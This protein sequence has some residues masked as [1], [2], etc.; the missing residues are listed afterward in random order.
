MV[1]IEE[2]ALG[3]SKDDKAPEKIIG[4]E[5]AVGNLF[6]VHTILED[7]NFPR[8]NQDLEAEE[9][10]KIRAFISVGCGCKQIYKG[11]CCSS[12][13]SI[14]EMKE[15]RQEFQSLDYYEN[16]FNKLDLVI[17]AKISTFCKDGDETV[18]NKKKKQNERQRSRSNFLIKGEP[19]CIKTFLFAHAICSWRF[20]RL[21]KIYLKEGVV[22]KLHGNTGR[23][24]ANTASFEKTKSAV[25]FIQNYA[26]ENSLF[27]PGRQAGHKN[28]THKLLPSSDNKK[29]IY[30]LYCKCCSE[31][32]ETSVSKRSF[33]RIWSTFCPDI[34]I[35][36]P[37]SDL[38]RK[39][40]SN[41]TTMRVMT[42]AS[43]EE[44]MRIN[45]DMHQH[46]EKVIKERSFYKLTVKNSTEAMKSQEFSQ[47]PRPP[48]SYD[49][50]CHYSFDFAQQ[51]Q[52][53]SNP[54]QPGP[55]YFLSPYKVGIFGI[56]CDSV[57]KQ[58][59]YLIPEAV[60]TTK[61]AN[62]VTSMLHHYFENHS[63][64]E[65]RVFFH[66][67]NCVAQNKNNIIMC[68][69]IWRVMEG[70]HDEITLSFLPVG[71][72][73][74]SCDWAFGL[75]KRK[76]RVTPASSLADIASIVEGS[77]PESKLNH[78]VLTGKEDGTVI[79]T[80]YDWQG[81]F[82]TLGWHKIPQITSYS[83]FS[84][85]KNDPG[86][87]FCQTE[88]NGPTVRIKVCPENNYPGIAPNMPEIMIPNGLSEKRKKYLYQQIRP[89]CTENTKD[90]LCPEPEGYSTSDSGLHVEEE[91]EEEQQGGVVDDQILEEA[92]PAGKNKGVK[93]NTVTEGSRKKNSSET[94]GKRK[95]R[96]GET[97]DLGSKKKGKPTK[98]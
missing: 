2:D 85:S 39:C 94:L 40:Q 59:N 11:E 3:D 7:N 61:G 62:C 38:C 84:T 41:Y 48:C 67:D 17:L 70:L 98:K 45:E 25:M 88:L 21:K 6:E 49:G 8:N 96:I 47:E 20:K 91:N 79:V 1:I 15:M 23:S 82:T 71:H 63:Y 64:G 68:Y 5:D 76:Y 33:Y 18:S 4:E 55:I 43:E 35:Q 89:Y 30:E 77:T 16:H 92:Q 51:V 50:F 80:M 56:M 44:K 54:L 9:E 75:F 32:G 27:L 31:K 58:H 29:Q 12:K 37:M 95:E 46:L 10:E 83:H 86:V 74:F 14:E 90:I 34:L 81:F 72:T 53:P 19:V 57:H 13:F 69:L 52:I 22:A 97:V 36:R 24:P 87:M 42:L 73:K 78:A 66:A 28:M 60:V 26:T 93:K 65:K